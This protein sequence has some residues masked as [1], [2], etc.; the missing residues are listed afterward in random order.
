[1][2]ERLKAWPAVPQGRGCL[3]S[4]RNHRR[5]TGVAGSGD[6]FQVPIRI[7]EFKNGAGGCI[8]PMRLAQ[9]LVRISVLCSKRDQVLRCPDGSGR[10]KGEGMK[11][12]WA[13]LTASGWVAVRR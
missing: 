11:S 13:W 2:P 4:A 10:A 6:A 5:D 12:G 7:P 9:R 3:A 1:M 8:Q